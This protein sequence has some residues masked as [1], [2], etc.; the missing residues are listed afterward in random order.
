MS[1]SFLDYFFKID[2]I[3]S[4]MRVLEKGGDKQSAELIGDVWVK[5]QRETLLTR[6]QDI[7]FNLLDVLFERKDRMDIALMRDKI[8]KAAEA[9]KIRLPSS[10]YASSQDVLL[11]Q[12]DLLNKIGVTSSVNR[13]AT[14]YLQA[15]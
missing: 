11:L 2:K 3:Y 4:V 5:L 9:L 13:I 7:A 10:V 8:F 14:R 6:N 15:K 1:V 12:K